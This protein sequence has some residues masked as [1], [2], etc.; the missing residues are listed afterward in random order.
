[1]LAGGTA[2]PVSSGLRAAI[3]YWL[4]AQLYLLA[5]GLIA[6]ILCWLV[7]QLYLLAGA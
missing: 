7:A 5:E 1:M 3:L 2:V 6:A 4:V